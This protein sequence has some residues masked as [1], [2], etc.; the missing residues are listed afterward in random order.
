MLAN[1]FIEI[2]SIDLSSDTDPPY[3]PN[4]TSTPNSF[5][6]ILKKGYDNLKKDPKKIQIITIF[7]NF[8]DLE[9]EIITPLNDTARTEFC[10]RLFGFLQDTSAAMIVSR[11]EFDYEVC[12]LVKSE[13]LKRDFKLLG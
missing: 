2:V 4:S 1:D 10:N 13:F 8:C 11:Q 3:K 12:V 7:Y 6:E 9:S 5:I